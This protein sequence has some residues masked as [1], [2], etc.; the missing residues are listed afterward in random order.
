MIFWIDSKI[1]KL[2]LEQRNYSP[3]ALRCNKL[4]F[5]LE[6]VCLIRLACNGR[7]SLSANL[8]AGFGASRAAGLANFGPRV[9]G[10]SFK[11]NG[12]SGRGSRD[13]PF[14]CGRVSGISPKIPIS[15]CFRSRT[16]HID[17]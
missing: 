17:N 6:F 1:E 8:E 14:F 2:H 5:L 16:V 9:L 11:S 13:W 10:F 4:F 15:S 7:N 3:L 12:F